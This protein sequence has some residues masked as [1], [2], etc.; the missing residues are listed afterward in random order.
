MAGLRVVWVGRTQQGF[1]EEGVAYYRDRIAPFQ[2]LEIVEV[3][4][5]G[6]SGRDPAQ[7][8]RREGEA[9]LKRIPPADPV[10]LLD[11]RGRELDTR[12]FAR[13]LA[14]R[15]QE[16]AR[17]LTFVVGGAYGVDAAV[18]DR[19]QDTLALSRLTFPHQ[20]VR[21]I[22]LEQLYRALS[23]LAGHAYHHE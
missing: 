7:A 9:I 14:A 1:V 13:W 12:A 10:A 2:P 3:R 15:Q 5:A 22:L 19:A 6:H 23:L 21:V 18:R 17:P 20:L 16:A 4:A 8:L 11:E